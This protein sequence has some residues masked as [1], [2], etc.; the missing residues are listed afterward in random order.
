MK[1]FLAFFLFAASALALT[2]SERQTVSEMRDTITLLR[3]S[4]DSARRANERS[5]NALASASA[6][7]TELTERLK[8]AADEAAQLAAERDHL[9]GEIAVAKVKYD[10]LNTR[11]QTAQL[12]IALVVGFAVGLIALQ[13]THALLPPYSVLVPIAA[14]IA[15]FFGIYIVL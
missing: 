15:A 2:P 1:T 7:T 6:Q 3:G 4:L 8:V 12:I 14:G 9:S 5:L 13:F 10:K 11:Y